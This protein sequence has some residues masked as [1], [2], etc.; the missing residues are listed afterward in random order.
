MSTPVSDDSALNYLAAC[1]EK[2]TAEQHWVV[3]SVT[4]V[5]AAFVAAAERLSF[6]IWLSAF[7]SVILLVALAFGIYFIRLRHKAYYFYR[8]AVAELLKGT[9]V[10]RVLKEPADR[11]TAEARSGM[12]LYCS[13][14]VLSS[15][16]A[17]TVLL[18]AG[19]TI[20]LR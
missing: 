12:L 13:W 8:D 6:T 20:H 17:V 3:A 16:F 4:A 1:A 19:L 14:I 5:D 18:V 11:S 7:A 9:E 10:P 2:C 15:C